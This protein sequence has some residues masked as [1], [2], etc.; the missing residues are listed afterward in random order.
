LTQQYD[1]NEVDKKVNKLNNSN[2][3]EF[4]NKDVLI[5]IADND[6]NPI[7]SF[8]RHLQMLNGTPCIDFFE[9]SPDNFCLISLPPNI[10]FHKN[11]I[12]LSLC[13]YMIFVNE[14]SY[15]GQLMLRVTNSFIKEEGSEK[16]ERN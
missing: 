9:S 14:S 2:L 8:N 13:R 5:T 3:E 16:N 12:D 4:I 10:A 7:H 15:L 11:E 1:D 6:F